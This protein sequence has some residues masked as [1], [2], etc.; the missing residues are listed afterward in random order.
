MAAEFGGDEHRQSADNQRPVLTAKRAFG[1][2]RSASVRRP[3]RSLGGCALSVSCVAHCRR[4]T[5]LA[6]RVWVGAPERLLTEERY[7]PFRPKSGSMSFRVERSRCLCRALR[8][9]SPLAPPPRAVKS[10]PP[11][12]LGGRPRKAATSPK[13][14]SVLAFLTPSRVRFAGLRPPLTAPSTLAT[15]LVGVAMPAQPHR[16]VVVRSTRNDI[17]RHEVAG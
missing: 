17:L 7:S 4:W 3:E 1:K 13:P 8:A 10:S 14:L 9:P 15:P 5:G 2:G 11:D 12:G 16:S 6:E